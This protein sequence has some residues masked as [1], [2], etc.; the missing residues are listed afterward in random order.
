MAIR[1][2]KRGTLIREEA[3]RTPRRIDPMGAQPQPADD[4]AVMRD[5]RQQLR[6]TTPLDPV[7]EKALLEK[8]SLGDRASLDRVVAANL[9]LV[10]RLAEA[11]HDSTLSVPDLVME[12]SIGLVEAARSFATSGE[13]DFAKFAARKV[14]DQMDS[15]IAAETAAVRDAELLVAA[16]SDYERTELLLARDLRRAPN[17]SEIAEKLEWTVERTRYVAQVVAEARRRHDEELLAFIDPDAID[18]DDTVDGE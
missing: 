8:S 14:G 7:D 13:P 6:S 12:G 18:F 9:G 17:E 4:D 11:H 16:A 5:L 15:A 2:V 3:H 10:I 1:H